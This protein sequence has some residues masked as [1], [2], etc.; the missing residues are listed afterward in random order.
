MIKLVNK[1][2]I[3]WSH[4]KGIATIFIVC[5]NNKR[6]A[7]RKICESNVVSRKPYYVSFSIYNENGEPLLERDFE[8]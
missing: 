4:K 8:G 7:S 5:K 6:S 2:W 3:R 1:K